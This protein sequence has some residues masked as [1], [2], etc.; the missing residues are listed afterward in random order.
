MILPKAYVDET[1]G[2]RPGPNQGSFN[3][4]IYS[5]WYTI[6]RKEQGSLTASD[7][8][9][10]IKHLALNDTEDGLYKPKN[11]HDNLTYKVIASKI[12]GLDVTD[13]MSFLKAIKD[14]GF[15]RFW[16]VITYGAVF[17]PKLLRPLFSIL[18]FI[19]A[20]QMIHGV[21]SEGKIRP[22]HFEKGGLFPWWFRSKALVKEEF[23]EGNQV[24]YKTWTDYKGRTQVTRHMQN[25]GKHLA[26]FRLYALKDF[27]WFK[28]C[29]KV[30]KKMLIARYGEDYTFEIINKY[31]RDR[32]HPLIKMWEGHGDIL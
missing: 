18:L 24:T 19:P 29:N 21:H 22:T 9:A 6:A 26:V 13:D 12:F 23:N 14:I 5:T 16:D 28:L 7:T 4:I 32:K 3:N 15:Y 8:D 1:G 20:L 27:F 2:V 11:S 31:F 25:D 17:G 10:L 30:V